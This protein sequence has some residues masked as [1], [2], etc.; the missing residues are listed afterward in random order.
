[1]FRTVGRGSSHSNDRG[2]R[3]GST[4][5]D[6]VGKRTLVEQTA[7]VQTKAE[8][9][10]AHPRASAVPPSVASEPDGSP[11]QRTASGVPFL[12]LKDTAAEGLAGASQPLPFSDT[13]QRVF[14]HHDVSGVRAAIGGPAATAADAMGAAAYA[15]GQRVAFA[16]APDLHTAA[17]EAAH[18]VQQRAGVHLFGGVG[19]AGDPYEQHADQVADLVVAGKS[20]QSLLDQKASP[21]G[22]SAP[23]GDAVQHVLRVGAETKRAALGNTTQRTLQRTHGASSGAIGVLDAWARD[24]VDTRARR[25]KDWPA[26][27]AAAT[28]VAA[29]A[30]STASTSAPA[31]AA[32]T[33]ST[34]PAGHAAAPAAHDDAPPAPQVATPTSHDDTPPAPPAT[35]PTSHD[36]AAPAPHEASS[37]TAHGEPAANTS[38]HAEP[39]ASSSHAEGADEASD[40]LAPLHDPGLPFPGLL[41]FTHETTPANLLNQLRGG[42][43]KSRAKLV[44]EGR[45]QSNQDTRK[46]GGYYVYTRMI[47]TN[48]TVKLGEGSK[49]SG[50]PIMIILSPSLA[51]RNDWFTT[52]IDLMGRVPPAIMPRDKSGFPPEWTLINAGEAFQRNGKGQMTPTFGMPAEVLHS[53]VDDQ[54][55]RPSA[56]NEQGFFGGIPLAY[57]ARI[58]VKRDRVSTSAKGKAAAAGP[59]RSSGAAGIASAADLIA[60]IRKD[61]ELE[62]EILQATGK[63]RLEELIVDK[64]KGQ[65]VANLLAAAPPA[66]APST[67]AGASSSNP[68]G[69]SASP[70]GD[71]PAPQPDASSAT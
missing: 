19:K 2:A 9:P 38:A 20:A 34:T 37:S 35:T 66:L 47:G 69:A 41:F 39:A 56:I 57:Y 52:G 60:E 67:Q 4:G 40:P 45:L 31:G 61:P 23:A 16:S 11:G 27:I 48:S 70:P 49:G 8:D 58:I 6:A 59:S 18:V 5:S 55:K 65:L 43:M 33:S 22:H 71:T 62:R 64:T 26:A 53:A 54:L 36:D 12:Q 15:S 14:G 63:A 68:S 1:M 29:A 50:S 24:Q 44:E 13:I 30:Q 28:N 10:A 7:A 21:G 32:P 3:T 42:G 51:A 46:G 17:H 25:F